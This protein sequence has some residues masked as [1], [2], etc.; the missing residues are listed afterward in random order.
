[1]SLSGYQPEEIIFLKKSEFISYGCF[2][3]T[4]IFKIFL[5]ILGCYTINDA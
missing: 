2:I 3:F 4:S 1:M 5:I